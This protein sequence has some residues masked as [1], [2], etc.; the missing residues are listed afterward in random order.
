MYKLNAKASENNQT[1]EEVK[2]EDIQKLSQ[3]NQEADSEFISEIFEAVKR[4]EET[5]GAS[6]CILPKTTKEFEKSTELGKIKAIRG[7]T[8]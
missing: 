6:H 4:N 3:V 1:D 7:L 2:V 5:P 8:P